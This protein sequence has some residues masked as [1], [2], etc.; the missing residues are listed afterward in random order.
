MKDL[1]NKQ[2]AVL[3]CIDDIAQGRFSVKVGTSEIAWKTNLNNL[4]VTALL[5][6]LIDRKYIR[7]FLVSNASTSGG[8]YKNAYSITAMGRNY[9]NSAKR[10]VATN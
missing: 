2:I 4:A 10:D 6:T 5:A 8:A 3:S 9:L 7:C 1:T